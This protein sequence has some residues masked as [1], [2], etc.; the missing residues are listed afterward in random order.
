MVWIKK[1]ICS[2]PSIYMTVAFLENLLYIL[3]IQKY[4]ICGRCVLALVIIN[5]SLASH[6]N[7]SEQG[8]IFILHH[9]CRVLNLPWSLPFS[10]NFNRPLYHYDNQNISQ[11]SS[12]ILPNGRYHSPFRTK[13]LRLLSDNNLPC[14]YDTVFPQSYPQH[15]AL[16]NV[17]IGLRPVG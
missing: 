10:L 16:H 17:L 8:K 1:K 14:L 6:E 2:Q 15:S 12:Q 13:N 4:L 5:S 3:I 11:K 9:Y 7:L